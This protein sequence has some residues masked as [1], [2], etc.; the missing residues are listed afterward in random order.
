MRS[1]II[2]V[3]VA[4]AFLL[5]LSAAAQAPASAPTSAPEA[6]ATAQPATPEAPTSQPG[7]VSTSPTGEPRVLVGLGLGAY[8]PTSKL[9]T[10]FL[11]GLDASYQLPWLSRKLGVGL[12]LGYS[13]PTTSGEIGDT[14]VPGGSAGYDTTMRELLL[15]LFLSY[16]FL[17]WSSVW[18]PHASIGP[19]FYFLS[20]QVDFNSRD[21]QPLTMEQTETSSQA[22]FL[23]TVGADYRIWRG[24]LTGEV[25][26]PF[27]TVGQKTTGDSNVGAV[28]IVLG[29]RLRI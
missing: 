3:T 18:S 24:A 15:E 17:S 4:L 29:Y 26:I 19:A 25:R 27:A 12:G 11:V 22:G 5:S 13:Q 23:F 16:R 7:V 1:S 28:S 2:A 21:A 10:N 9:K 6:I 20:H 8:V 14:R